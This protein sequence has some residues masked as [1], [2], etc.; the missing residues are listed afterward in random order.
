MA[1]MRLARRG[2]IAQHRGVVMPAGPLMPNEPDGLRRSFRPR[3]AQAARLL[4]AT[5]S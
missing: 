4:T 1:N 5:F 2:P 3:G